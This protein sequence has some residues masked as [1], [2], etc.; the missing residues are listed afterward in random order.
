MKVR[1]ERECKDCG[2]RWSY[3][4][5]GDVECPSCGSMRSVGVSERQQ[6]TDVGGELDLSE[7]RQAAANEPLRRAASVAEDAC[8]SFVTARG[9]IS[10]GELLE[11]DDVYVAA[12]ELK[13]AASEVATRMDVEDAVETYFL[14]LLQGAEEGVRPETDAVPAMFRS[15]RGLGIAAV[16]KAYRLDL[17]EIIDDTDTE[18]PDDALRFISRLGEH[19]KRIR[20]L[21]G[22]IDPEYADAVLEAARAVGRYVGGGPASAD[23]RAQADE[24]LSTLSET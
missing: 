14:E 12:Q 8:R 11:L 19:E 4:E 10:G 3:Y 15:A 20:A 21:D 13:H 6:H 1:G 18:T 2:A 9:F 5:T 7:A 16:V 22:D 23:S 17:R 24:L